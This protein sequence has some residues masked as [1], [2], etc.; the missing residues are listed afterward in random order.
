LHDNGLPGDPSPEWM[1][2]HQMGMKSL[3]PG[4]LSVTDQLLGSIKLRSSILLSNDEMRY[5]G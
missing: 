1:Q 3:Q 5:S 4:D 2:A